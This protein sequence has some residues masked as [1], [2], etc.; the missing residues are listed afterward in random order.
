MVNLFEWWVDYNL[1]AYF[2]CRFIHQPQFG[3]M[4]NMDREYGVFLER[5]SQEFEQQLEVLK[6]EEA[7]EVKEVKVEGEGKKGQVDGTHQE[8]GH[9][10]EGHQE[11]GHQEE[12]HQ[13]EE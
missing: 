10:E 5:R 12:V 7:I 11:E 2:F 1:W 6:L 9:Q 13:K 3:G 8:E 4:E